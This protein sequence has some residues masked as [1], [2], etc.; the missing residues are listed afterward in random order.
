VVNREPYAVIASLHKFHH[1]VFASQIVVFSDHCP[2]SFLVD[3]ATHSSKLTR[4]SLALKQYNSVFQY[5]KARRNRVAD[6]F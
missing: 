3:W 5:A 1:L 6:Y 2:L 4:W